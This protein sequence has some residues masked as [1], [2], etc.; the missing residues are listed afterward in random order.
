MSRVMTL[1]L[2]LRVEE[3]E[4]KTLRSRLTAIRERQGNPMGVEIRRIGGASLFTIKGIPGPSFNKVLGATGS[5]VDH[6]DEIIQAFRKQGIPCRF[7]LIPGH[8][9]PELFGRLAD[10]GF[11]QAGFHTV[12]YGVPPKEQGGAPVE[13]LR[14]AEKIEVFEVNEDEF[15][16]FGEL[17]VKGFGLPALLSTGIADNNRVL[18]GRPGWKFYIAFVDGQAAGIGVLYMEDGVG[19]LAAACTVPEMRRKGCHM[20]LIQR[21][22]ADA[23]KGGCDLIIGQAVFG[24]V[25][26][27]NMQRIGMQIAYTKSI[28]VERP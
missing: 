15:G 10:S 13:G 25:S 26:Q 9:T 23:R 18:H 24:S 27:Q 2:A 28:W 17:Y 12:L 5:D 4:I 20:A 1:D 22:I 8:V 19:N 6:V 7:E 11:Y 16:L 14:L 3:A 21:R